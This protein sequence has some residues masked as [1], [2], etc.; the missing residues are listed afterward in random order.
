MHLYLLH[1]TTFFQKTWMTQLLPSSGY[2]Q[3]VGI[4]NRL[5]VQHVDVKW[6]ISPCTNAL[7]TDSLRDFKSASHSTYQLALRSLFFGFP[8]LAM[9]GRWKTLLSPPS[10]T[11]PI[12]WEV[13]KIRII[14][15]TALYSN[16]GPN[17][18]TTALKADLADLC[19][20][21]EVWRFCI[22]RCLNGTFPW[23]KCSIAA[24]VN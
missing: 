9:T 13:S 21:I 22:I 7:L 17:H 12:F 3:I 24:L 20:D 14:V 11:P 15:Y 18:L 19:Q 23:R 10:L 4:Q 6:Y 5:Y 16:Y 1:F 8:W 2:V